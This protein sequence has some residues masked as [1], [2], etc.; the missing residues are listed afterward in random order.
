M[1]WYGNYL[2]VIAFER[3]LSYLLTVTQTCLSLCLG[4]TLGRKPSL[5]T[6][7]PSAALLA[8]VELGWKERGKELLVLRGPNLS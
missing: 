5:W 2:R 8:L 6:P 7:P 1:S 3:G 4:S